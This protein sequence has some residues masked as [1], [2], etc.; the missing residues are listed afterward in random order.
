MNDYDWSKWGGGGIDLREVEMKQAADRARHEALRI[1]EFERRKMSTIN[2]NC[3]DL[4]NP[5]SI[6]DRVARGELKEETL[7]TRHK[8][9]NLYGMLEASKP[10]RDNNPYIVGDGGVE[11]LEILGKSWPD[12]LDLVLR[13]RNETRKKGD[14]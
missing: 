2:I 3:Q 11:A 9:R 7:D 1:Q 4:T 8:D 14:K 5:P 13:M 10:Y 12:T 6:P